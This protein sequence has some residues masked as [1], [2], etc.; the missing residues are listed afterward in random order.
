MSSGD[1]QSNLLKAI[2]IREGALLSNLTE[3]NLV[4]GSIL[5]WRQNTAGGGSCFIAK[6]GML[7]SYGAQ[8]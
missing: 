2:E 5:K 3:A 7:H 1:R 8:F 4:S 6:L